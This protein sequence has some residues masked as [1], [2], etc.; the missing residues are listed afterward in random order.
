MTNDFLRTAYVIL[1]THESVLTMNDLQLTTGYLLRNTQYLLLTTHSVPHPSD[2]LLPTTY[3]SLLTADHLL[4][5]GYFLLLATYLLLTCCYL[6]LATCYLPYV[7]WMLRSSSPGCATSLRWLLRSA[8][9]ESHS[10]RS[11][12]SSLSRFSS[13]WPREARVIGAVGLHAYSRTCLCAYSS[14]CSS[15]CS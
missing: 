14:I 3:Y 12:A 11:S 10:T 2:Y 13:L 7:R 9:R 8:R 6:L 15:I 1:S 4:L 5:T